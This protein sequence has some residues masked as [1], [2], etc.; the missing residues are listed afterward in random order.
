MVGTVP[1]DW[2][3]PSGAEAKSCTFQVSVIAFHEKA[4][5]SQVDSF[6][7]SLN[8]VFSLC[9][10]ATDAILP[11]ALFD[12]R[13][14]RSVQVGRSRFSRCCHLFVD[15]F[16]STLRSWPRRFTQSPELGFT[17]LIFLSQRC[18]GFMPRSPAAGVGGCA[19]VRTLLRSPT[20]DA[21]TPPAFVPSR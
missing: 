1:D 19:A 4:G 20:G 9:R 13:F 15:L 5:R 18:F 16:F 7:F 14:S 6:G 8:K 10:V 17:L 12:E 11:S 2:G 3:S 21:A